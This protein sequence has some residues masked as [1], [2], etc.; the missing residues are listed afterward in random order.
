M[1]YR[2]RLVLIFISIQ[3]PFVLS[4]LTIRLGQAKPELVIQVDTFD[5][6]M[7]NDEDCSLR[8]A[9]QAANNNVA[10]DGCTAGSADSIDNIYLPAGTYTLS[11]AGADNDNLKGD[12]D[13]H[14]PLN[15]YGD[16]ADTTII[17]GGSLD[18]IF[19]IHQ[20]DHE[21]SISNIT[22]QNGRVIEGT[23]GGS[24]IMVHSNIDLEL[25]DCRIRNN[26]TPDFLGGGIDNYNGKVTIFNC[27][28]EDN[29]A[30][31]G[32]G[33]YNDGE[34]TIYNTLI[35]NNNASGAG[36]GGGISNSESGL[37][38]GKVTAEN[39][40]ISNNT[41]D[42]GSGIFSSTVIT[43]TNATIA[44]NFGSGAAFFNTGISYL[45]NTILGLNQDFINCGGIGNF[46]TLGNNL[47]DG[48]SCHFDTQLNDQINT[49]PLLIGDTPQDNGGFTN[50][51]ALEMNS[52]A[53]DKGTNTGCPSTDQRGYDRPKDGD[54]DGTA[55]CDIGAFEANELTILYFPLLN[56]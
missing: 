2:H 7:N 46:E 26:H 6:E 10:I 42:N 15:L 5:D 39:I 31:E 48:S 33:I 51:F 37:G 22:I 36:G 50:T 4:V 20:N 47:E 53:I 52:P 9:I 55:I 19:Q 12:L 43:I 56:K 11:I 21:V 32:G 3:I 27:I 17:D 29:S 25:I 24:G 45:K 23:G 30:L 34:L 38:A 14:G 13:I 1:K 40:T 18:R 49:N 41:G 28:I 8:E 16:S 54:G 35:S 44:Y